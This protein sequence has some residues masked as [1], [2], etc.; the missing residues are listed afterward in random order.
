ER[1][2]L[3][4][5]VPAGDAFEQRARRVP[6]AFGAAGVHVVQVQVGVDVGRNDQTAPQIDLLVRPGQ[7]PADLPDDAPVD[8]H[9]A[10]F[11]VPAVDPNVGEL[12]H[13]SLLH[14]WMAAIGV[15]AECDRS[16]TR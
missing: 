10:G 8:Q 7:I 13:G 5:V 2:G 16:G 14:S 1:L 9:L 4:D 6:R 3:L 15:G 11:T 12:L